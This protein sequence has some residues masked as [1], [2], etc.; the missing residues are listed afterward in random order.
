MLI[1]VQVVPRAKRQR[2]EVTKGGL[3]VYI[4]TSPIEG[5]ANKKLIDLLADYYQVKKY[6]I[7]IVKGKK[8]KNKI[9]QIDEIN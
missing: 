4:S 7:S 8:Q 2:V 9:I 1:M 3:K 6:N 5:K